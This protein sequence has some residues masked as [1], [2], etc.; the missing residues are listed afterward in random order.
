MA[1]GGFVF[2][3]GTTGFN[4]ENKHVIEYRL[5]LDSN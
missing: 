4:N 1:H 5:T 2:R 3:T